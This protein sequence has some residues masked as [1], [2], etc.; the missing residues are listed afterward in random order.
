MTNYLIIAE[1]RELADAVRKAIGIGRDRIP[2]GNYNVL[3]AAGHLLTLKMP[4]EYDPKY[5]TWNLEDLPI[6][7]P[8]WQEVPIKGKEN[9]LQPIIS[10]MQEADIIVNCGDPD[11]EGQYLVDQIIYGYLKQKKPVKR[12]LINDN[13]P[14]Y[15]IKQLRKMEDNYPKYWLQ[16][17]GA[18]AR[19]VSDAIF[20]FNY[21]RWYSVSYGQR[22]TVGRVQ[23]PTL[24]L[25]VN[26]DRQIESHVSRN[27][28][29]LEIDALR[30]GDP[31]AV[32]VKYVPNPKRAELEEGKFFDHHPLEQIADA[33]NHKCMDGKV[34]RQT[35]DTLPPLP[36][37]MSELQS[38][39]SKAFKYTPTQVMEIT[40]SLRSKALITYNR[41]DC[42]Y[43]HEEM[44]ADAPKVLNAIQQSLNIQAPVDQRIKSRAFSDKDVA[45]APHHAIIPTATQFNPASLSQQELNVYK[46]IAAYYMIQFMPPCKKETV[47]L[48][49]PLPEQDKLQATDSK[50]TDPGFTSFLNKIPKD[51]IS[52]LSRIP[53][54]THQFSLSGPAVT[55]HQ[56]TPP[57]R[58]TQ[59]SLIKDMCQVSK[60]AS[61]PRIRQLFLT[62]D[63]ES[64]NSGSIGTAATRDSIVKAL[65][66][67]SAFLE[68]YQEGKGRYIRSTDKG[69]AFFDLLPSQL[70]SLDTTVLWWEITQEIQKGN[71][72][73]EALTDSVIDQVKEFLLELPKLKEA[74][75]LPETVTGKTVVGTCPRCG[76]QIVEGKKGYGCLGYKDNPPCS[77]I[78]WKTSKLLETGNKTVTLEMARSLLRDGKCGIDGLISKTGKKYGGIL[79]LKDDDEKVNLEFRF[80]TEEEQSVGPCPRCGRPVTENAKGFGCSGYRDPENQC[81]F[82]LSKDPPILAKN[83]KKLTVAMAKKLLSGKTCHITGL[84]SGSGLKYSADF[85]LKDNGT[86]ANLEIVQK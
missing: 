77:F 32:R 66:E 36:F 34:K 71:K 82:F 6:A 46:A 49:I 53:D 31:E 81:R 79:E 1:K 39:C 18:Y 5:K 65:I 37:D 44:H 72:P 2:A 52:A 80:R 10:A 55:E 11:D 85:I 3:P 25:V 61:D 54:G 41:S 16:G 74:K 62:R 17:R 84:T 51:E 68:E 43:L 27:Y 24:G 67:K 48:T 70:K 63:A 20:G 42:R 57:K 9:L 60:Y 12:L 50:V 8:N 26:R 23:T 14:E 86:Y 78:I 21:S 22:L 56:T 58:Y 33:I 64:K 7:F 45:D 76:K 59:A 35:K 38:Y 83:R 13:S 73:V 28:Y 47:T 69:R 15:I 19:S 40:Q 4:E 30:T 29:E 75:G